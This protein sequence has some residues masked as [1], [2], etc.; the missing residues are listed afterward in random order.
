[1]ISVTVNWMVGCV[2]IEK[3]TNSNDSRNHLVSISLIIPV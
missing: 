3:K 2:L 1:M